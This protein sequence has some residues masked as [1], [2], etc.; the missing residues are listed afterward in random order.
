MNLA[1]RILRKAGNA[2][3]QAAVKLGP[4][5]NQAK[6]VPEPIQAKRVK[7]WFAANGDKT[8]RLDYALNA[9]A[10]V[11]DLGGYEGEWAADIFC[12]YGCTLHIFEPYSVYCN[13][14]KNRFA[15]NSKVFVH[16][17]GLAAVTSESTLS[18]DDNS[19]SMFKA[20]DSS[21]GIQLLAANEFFAQ[22]AISEIQLM[23]VNIEGGEYDLLDHLLDTGE[24]NKIINLQVQFH[25]FVPGAA[26]R[27]KKIQQRL[28]ETHEPTYQFEFVWE[29][30]RRKA[31]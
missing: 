6:I 5:K 16:E 17:L 28:S 14:I 27:M 15:F 1:S 7:P 18:I 8:L 31:R 22:H 12:R 13:N 20:G 21:V 9:N 26:H 10:V 29:N 11:F 3:Q 23:K 2:L 19:S 30:W 25:D 24:I 4:E